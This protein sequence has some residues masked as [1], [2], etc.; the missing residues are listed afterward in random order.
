MEFD[1]RIYDVGAI[2]SAAAA[3][4]ELAHIELEMRNQKLLCTFTE[5][6]F[7]KNTTMRE[8]GNYVIGCMNHRSEI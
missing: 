8:F 6:K 3:F 2:R 5:C 1:L 7:G 4:R